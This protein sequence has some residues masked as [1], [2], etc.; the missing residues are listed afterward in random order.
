[1]AD[2][3]VV[4]AAEGGAAVAFLV[5]V[6]VG[7]AV[8]VAAFRGAVAAVFRGPV[9][10]IS[11]EEVP[12]APLGRETFPAVTEAVA[13]AAEAVAWLIPETPHRATEVPLAA[14]D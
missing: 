10:E 11:P 9:E 6:A 8:A 13:A 5:V 7:A 14:S 3:A 4:A 2:A 1:V 12:V